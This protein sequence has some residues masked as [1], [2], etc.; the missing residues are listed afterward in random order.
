MVAALWSAARRDGPHSKAPQSY[1]TRPKPSAASSADPLFKVRG[2]SPRPVVSPH[3]LLDG[4]SGPRLAPLRSQV[5]CFFALSQGERVSRSGAFTS[6]SGPG[7]GVTRDDNELDSR[8]RG[9]D[10]TFDAT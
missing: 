5:E 2:F 1:H 7:E 4:R 9:N 6:R 8:L 3:V 10:V